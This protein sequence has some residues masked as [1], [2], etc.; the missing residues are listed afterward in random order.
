MRVEATGADKVALKISDNGPGV[1]DSIARRIFDPF[2]TTKPQGTG[3][4]I[5]LSFSQGIA[6]AHGGSLALLPSEAGALFRL[7]LPVA[8]TCSATRPG[9][10]SAIPVQPRHV[11]I[12]DDEPELAET[13]AR[14]LRRQG[15]KADVAVGG[16]A[17]QERLRAFDYDLIFFDLR[18][19][20]FDGPA[21][22]RWLLAERPYLAERIA[23][24]TG[25]TLGPA[26]VR[27][28]EE[29]GRPA[30]EKP[31]TRETVNDLL[32]RIASMPTK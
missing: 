9:V 18:M 30:L 31:F 26:A 15:L 16:L 27:F 3:T 29:S 14:L 28:L 23:F 12:V 5:G 2:F 21:L 20:D 25:D 10:D 4:G 22:Y 24:V 19:P 8:L 32:A 7:E 6:E 13:M 17:G 1:P 11:L